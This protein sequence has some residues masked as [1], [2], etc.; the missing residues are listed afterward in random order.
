MIIISG[1][2]FGYLKINDVVGKVIDANEAQYYRIFMDVPGFE[3]AR[4]MENGDSILVELNTAI[5]SV[6]DTQY[7]NI[8][9]KIFTALVDYI[10]DFERIV[11]EPAYRNI[12]IN[13]HL[14]GWPLVSQNEI[15]TAILLRNNKRMHDIFC[16]MSCI[17][18]G[19]ASIGSCLGQTVIETYYDDCGGYSIYKINPYIF[20]AVT[21][22]GTGGGYLLASSLNRANVYDRLLKKGILAF[23]GYRQPITVEDCEIMGNMTNQFIFGCTGLVVSSIATIVTFAFIATPYLGNKPNTVWDGIMVWVPI[24]SFSFSELITI[25]KFGV[26]LGE[27]QDRKATIERIKQKRIKEHLEKTKR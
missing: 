23:D 21:A 3:T 10:R 12:Y 2:V 4:F 1:F 11:E 8:D 17:I 6:H 13:K 14:I 24:A 20:G 22:T 19:S 5:D 15:D 9:K 16:C 26:D 27:K 7:R 18:P 25:T